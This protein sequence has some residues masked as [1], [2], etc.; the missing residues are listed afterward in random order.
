MDTR[1]RYLGLYVPP[2]KRPRPDE[3]KGINDV[4]LTH[5]RHHLT[6]NT[7]VVSFLSANHVEMESEDSSTV[8]RRE[9]GADESSRGNESFANG[10]GKS[11]IE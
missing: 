10:D 3:T 6:S 1:L 7:L 2:Q 8:G 11:N 9:S 5:L 4:H